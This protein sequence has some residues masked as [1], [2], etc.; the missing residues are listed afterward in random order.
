MSSRLRVAWFSPIAEES[1]L[2][3][4]QFS[5]AAIPCLPSS[6]EIEIF[7]SDSDWMSLAT[8]LW[9]PSVCGCSVF[10]YQRAF[11]RHESDP[12]DVF[13]YHLEDHPAASFVKAGMG[14]WP[15]IVFVHDLNLSRLEK[16]FI[17]HA[18]TE[19]LLNERTQEE[20]GE[21][22]ISVGDLAARGWST[23]IFERLYPLGLS[24][25]RNAGVMISPNE[26]SVDELKQRFPETPISRAEFPLRLLTTDEKEMHR[27][28]A[29]KALGLDARDFVIMCGA[30]NSVEDRAYVTLDSIGQLLKGSETS[31]VKVVWFVLDSLAEQT[32]QRVIGG[33]SDEILR[34]RIQVI[35]I[36]DFH[37]LQLL[38]CAADCVISL[39][40]DLLR[41]FSPFVYVAQAASVPL[42][43]S[44]FGPS[45]ELGTSLL[46]RVGRGEAQEL[47]RILWC[48]LSDPSF[49]Q[50]VSRRMRNVAE[51]VN[52]PKS[53]AEDIQ[54]IVEKHINYLRSQCQNSESNIQ[55]A[56]AS[57]LSKFERELS[58][59]KL[60]LPGNKEI[61]PLQISSK[62]ISDFGWGL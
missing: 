29:R 24:E 50:E 54:A 35:R 26:R 16:S 3:S 19:E 48:L 6:W 47:A 4:P 56:K 34:E 39:K 43:M 33:Y 21:K 13:I 32:I 60:V 25:L 52:S 40:F 41:G 58:E 61:D 23:E 22:I 8:E 5:R 45:S 28:E 51:V 42:I 37:S 14:V 1:L 38:T 62:L 20:F 7:T 9:L 30:Q 46:V 11:L 55:V 15:G 36:A 27:G 57:T 44:D 31:H 2:R 53:V 49:A 12:F 17:A 10:P 59:Q 18:T